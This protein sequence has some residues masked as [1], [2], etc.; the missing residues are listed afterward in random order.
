MTPLALSVGGVVALIV[1]AR[2]VGS[3]VFATVWSLIAVL[4]IFVQVSNFRAARYDHRF[5]LRQNSRSGA[6]LAITAKNLRHNRAR[7]QVVVINAVIGFVVGA[8]PFI[9]DVPNIPTSVPAAVTNYVITVGIFAG[10]VIM[11]DVSVREWYERTRRGRQRATA[12]RGHS[13][14]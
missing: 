13:H 1:N 6:V 8:A 14:G 4:G 2:V 7:L 10:E 12:D 9:Y 3:W 11:V 5:W